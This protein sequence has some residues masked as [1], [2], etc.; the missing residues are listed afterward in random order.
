MKRLDQ[1]AC[2]SEILMRLGRISPDTQRLWGRMSAPQMIC[3][4]SDCYLS[5]MGDRPMEIPARFT[6]LRAIKSIVLY[7][8]HHWPHGVPT[9]P[10]FD[11]VDG[12]GTP[13]SDFETD[14]HTLLEA[15][16]RFTAQPRAFAFRTHPMFGDMSEKDWMRWAYLHAD[17]HLR[18]FGC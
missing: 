14:L 16:G 10:E 7:M 3:H 9:R 6:W 15:I 11:Q 2:R 1:P 17:H 4:L 12:G 13:P 5:V 8:P 18:Q